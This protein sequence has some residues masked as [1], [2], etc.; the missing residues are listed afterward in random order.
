MAGAGKKWAIGCGIGCGLI[1]LILGG[2]GAFSYFTV[3]KFKGRADQLEVVQDQLDKKFGDPTSFIPAADGFIAPERMAV[4]LAV[5]DSMQC[6]RLALSNMLSSLDGDTNITVKIRSGLKLVPS[7]LAF[8]G[9]RNRA[10]LARDMG[11][12]EYQYIYTLAYYSLLGEGPGDGPGFILYSDD[13]DKGAVRVEWGRRRGAKD[14]HRKR[15]HRVRKFINDMQIPI[16]NNQWDAFVAAQPADA[17]PLADPWGAQLADELAAMR[18]DPLR[19]P[20]QDGLPEPLLQSLDP[21]RD[22][23]KKT[24]DP[25]TSIVEMGLA[26]GD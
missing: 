12:G 20:W 4:F 13:E 22:D 11:L 14:V 19:I 7:V 26:E 3:K 2:L 16:L 9:R 24:Y 15:A 18:D 8:V 21:Y 23:L 5:R 10:L 1:L 25:M 6:E 17:D